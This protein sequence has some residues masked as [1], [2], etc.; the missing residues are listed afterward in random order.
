M[1]L[2]IP[3]LFMRLFPGLKTLHDQ[4]SATDVT[5][6][7]PFFAVIYPTLVEQNLRHSAYAVVVSRVMLNFQLYADDGATRTG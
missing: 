3:G 4:Y 1:T 6:S 5:P 2:G 7:T